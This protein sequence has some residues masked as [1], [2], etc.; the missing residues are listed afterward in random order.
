MSGEI[1][2]EQQHSMTLCGPEWKEKGMQSSVMYYTLS[3]VHMSFFIIRMEAQ[4]TSFVDFTRSNMLYTFQFSS[5]EQTLGDICE[6]LI[7]GDVVVE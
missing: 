2:S 3:I 7:I 4:S 6:F 5:V 1:V